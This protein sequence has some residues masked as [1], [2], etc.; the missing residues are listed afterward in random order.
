MYI[1][2]YPTQIREIN[3]QFVIEING[4]VPE[5]GMMNGTVI[6]RNKEAPYEIGYSSDAWSNPKEYFTRNLHTPFIAIEEC[7]LDSLFP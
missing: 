6:R 1:G 2:D 7:H 5:K 4:P 3:R